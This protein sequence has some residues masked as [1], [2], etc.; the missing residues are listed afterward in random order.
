MDGWVSVTERLPEINQNI[1][2]STGQLFVGEGCYR[3]EGKWAQ[4]RWN[5]SD[6]VDVS[7]WMPLPGAPVASNNGFNLTPPVAGAS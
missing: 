3:G 2:I 5:I 7:H 6:M 4:Y 1:L